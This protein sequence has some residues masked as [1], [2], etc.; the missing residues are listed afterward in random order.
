[1]S[2]TAAPTAEN[3]GRHIDHSTLELWIELVMAGG[4]WSLREIRQN[5]F[6]AAEPAA[7]RG[8]VERLCDNGMVRERRIG[9]KHATF[10]VTTLCKAPP[11]YE[12]L[13]GVSA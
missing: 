2:A 13:M 12:H 7:V 6:A 8:M 9:S 5:W 10:G 1:M 11:G 3:A 4:Y